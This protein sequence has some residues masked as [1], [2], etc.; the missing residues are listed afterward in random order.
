L[1]VG[2][3]GTVSIPQGAERISLAG[4]TVIPGLINAHGHVS[5]VARDLRVYSAYGVTTVFSLGGEQAAHI[6][7]REKQAAGA[8]DGAR[9]FLSRAVLT[10]RT[11]GGAAA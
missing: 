3:T 1:A 6:A 2:A 7:A 4:K 11:P 8:L 9:L 10:R 5:D